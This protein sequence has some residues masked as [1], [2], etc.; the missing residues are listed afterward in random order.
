MKK[1]WIGVM[2]LLQVAVL[3]ACATQLSG[4][5]EPNGKIQVVTTLFPQY[6]FARA[7]GKDKAEVTLLL[8]P[9]VESHSY[10][11]TPKDVVRIQKA[12]LFIFTGK[13]MEPWADKTLDG[14]TS[15]DLIVVDA[16]IGVPLLE[17]ADK[18]AFDPHIW[19]DPNNAMI[20]IDTILEAFVTADPENKAFYEANAEAYKTE[21]RALDQEIKTALDGMENKTI[22]YGGH[23]AFGYFAHRYGLSYLSPYTGFTPDA[24]PTPQKIAEMIDLM[25]SM[26]MKTIYFEELIDPKV[27]RVIADETGAKLLLL[28]G[29]HNISKDELKNGVT[30]IQ[31]MKENLERLKEGLN[32]E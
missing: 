29:A 3:S 11:P 2:I 18:G 14:I 21:L 32:G 28:H 15:S 16:S 5:P 9:G 19:T 24:E 26:K 23:F 27:A 25:K 31:I 4:E 13:G 20:M 17:D 10:D 30:Y 12:D 1:L 6:D 22:L 7:I 8:P